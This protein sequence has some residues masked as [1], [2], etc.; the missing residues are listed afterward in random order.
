MNPNNPFID[1]LREGGC[2]GIEKLDLY[3]SN[4]EQAP[5]VKVHLSSCAACQA[6]LALLQSFQEAEATP[7]EADDVKWILDQAKASKKKQAPDVRPWWK[8]WLGN[9]PSRAWIGMAAAVAVVV[10]AVG[11]QQNSSRLPELPKE[12]SGSTLRASGKI[13]VLSPSAGNVSAAPAEVR[14]KPVAGAQRYEVLW[15]EVDGSE[16]A[17]GV[18]ESPV[19]VLSKANRM[20]FLPHKTVGIKIRARAADG[21]LLAE[22]SEMRIRVEP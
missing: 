3:R 16:I 12:I 5:D 11:V 9:S 2:P 10:V 21:K 7:G 6:E 20:V 22:S 13:E 19:Y 15:V 17:G 8:Y 14:W 1:N 18:A 4:P